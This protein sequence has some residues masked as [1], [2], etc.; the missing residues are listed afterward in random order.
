MGDV[1]DRAHLGGVRVGELRASAAALGVDD[2]RLLGS[3][4]P[5]PVDGFGQALGTHVRD[6]GHGFVELAPA[7]DMCGVAS[8]LADI[9]VPDGTDF[10]VIAVAERGG[11]VDDPMA[12]VLEQLDQRGV[13]PVLVVFP[14]QGRPAA[15]VRM[16]LAE[17]LVGA[18]GEQNMG[19]QWWDDCPAS[20]V[21]QVRSASGDLTAVGAD[22]VARMIAA[23]IG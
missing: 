3:I 21:V 22:R 20:G 1:V 4:D 13:E 9:E 2:V 5:L 15:N 8:G 7:T 19:C 14:G 10:L 11:C 6:R 12:S 23:T 17:Q 18:P 16:V